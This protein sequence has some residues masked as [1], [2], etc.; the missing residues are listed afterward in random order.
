MFSFYPE[1]SINLEVLLFH[2]KLFKHELQL[3]QKL[4]TMYH[5]CS[6]VSLV[7]FFQFDWV[8]VCYITI[9]EIDDYIIY[10][11]NNIYNGWYMYK[12]TYEI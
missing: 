1:T 11:Y 10:I 7:I 8:W 5:N 3:K 9:N 6:F 4:F 2:S 12:T